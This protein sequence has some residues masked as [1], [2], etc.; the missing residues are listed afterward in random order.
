MR[1]SGTEYVERGETIELQCNASG[2]TEPPHD[3]QWLRDDLTVKSDP[4]AGVLVS[5]KIEAQ[6]LLSVL[7]IQR[8]RFSDAGQYVCITSDQHAASVIIHVL[9]GIRLSIN[10]SIVFICRRR[11]NKI[12]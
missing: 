3:L 2:K 7:T 4:A 12:Q 8:S 1:I 6:Y 5:K 9:S 11:I 10:Q